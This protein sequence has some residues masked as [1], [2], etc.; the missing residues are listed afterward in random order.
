MI[1]LQLMFQ[2]CKYKL[3]LTFPLMLR[4]TLSLSITPPYSQYSFNKFFDPK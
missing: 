1:T 4:K 3:S 2:V